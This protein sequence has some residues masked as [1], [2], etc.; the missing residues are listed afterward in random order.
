MKE[1]RSWKEMMR[2][3][4]VNTGVDVNRDICSCM[5]YLVSCLC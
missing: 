3:A 5:Y 4:Y 1:G 2:G